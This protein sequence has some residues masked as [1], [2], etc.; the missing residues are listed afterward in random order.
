MR[1]CKRLSKRTAAR[2]PVVIPIWFLAIVFPFFG[3][4]N[5]TVDHFLLASPSSFGFGFGGW[6]CMVNFVHQIDTFGLISKW[7]L[8]VS[9][10]ANITT[11]APLPPLLTIN[12][13]HPH[14]P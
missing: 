5:S 14:R 13:T 7:V 11:T 2:L 1:E 10:I 4:S 9:S 6:G 3:P 8:L 12:L